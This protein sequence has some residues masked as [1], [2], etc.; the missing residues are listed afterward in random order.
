MHEKWQASVRAGRGTRC[1]VLDE[2]T[3][4][5]MHRLVVLVQPV[6]VAPEEILEI[7][8]TYINLSEKCPVRLLSQSL[9]FFGYPSL[10]P[11]R[12]SAQMLHM[13]ETAVISTNRNHVL[14][15]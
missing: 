10:K 2:E 4:E 13:Q 11:E 12:K 6:I 3:A 9:R 8:L 1:K 7:E 5:G 15:V 14:D